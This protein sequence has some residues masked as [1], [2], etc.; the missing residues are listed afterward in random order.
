MPRS[1]DFSED[2]RRRVVEAHEAGKGYKTISKMCELHHSTVRKIIY[3][4]KAF[5]TISTLPRSGRPI[6]LA[7]VLPHLRRGCQG[8]KITTEGVRVNGK[9]STQVSGTR[10][11]NTQVSSTR[12]ESA[13]VSGTR[14]ESTLV[15]ENESIKIE[16]AS[17]SAKSEDSRVSG[18][19]HGADCG[20]VAAAGEDK[21]SMTLAL[22]D[23]STVTRKTTKRIRRKEK[24]NCNRELGPAPP[25]AERHMEV[26]LCCEICGTCCTTE[27]D[28]ESHQAQHLDKTLHQCEECGR[29]FQTAA[30]LRAHR[31]RKHGC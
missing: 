12:A 15:S 27:T 1:K 22:P 21:A 31:K 25:P 28:L 13:R 6:K 20:G 23:V 26:M 18:T 29:A 24:L 17:V 11:E 19:D 30:G 3:K 9:E 5:N 7:T 2:V 14:A 10:A 16:E 8:Q 4:W